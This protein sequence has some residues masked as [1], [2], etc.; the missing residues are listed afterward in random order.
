MPSIS[1]QVFHESE[2]C[3][4]TKQ[5]PEPIKYQHDTYWANNLAPINTEFNSAKQFKVYLRDPKDLPQ[6]TIV[7]TL[8]LCSGHNRVF[9]YNKALGTLVI[10]AENWDRNKSELTLQYTIGQKEN[11][12]GIWLTITCDHPDVQLIWANLTPNKTKN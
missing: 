2:R 6:S 3:H 4:H 7:H 10:C 12:A 9:N 5:S 8:C 11:E 1:I